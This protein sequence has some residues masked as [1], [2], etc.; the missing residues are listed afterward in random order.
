MAKR[1]L[2]LETLEKM[3]QHSKTKNDVLWVG[4]HDGKYCITWD[5]FSLLS[6]KEYDRDSPRQ[7]VA[8]DLVIA[9]NGWWLERKE[10]Q[11]TEWWVFLELPQKREGK[12]FQKIFC[13]E[14]KSKG[15]MSLEEI[16][17]AF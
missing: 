4:S 12:T 6:D 3:E 7:I 5:E 8:K 15:W 17:T 9:G 14:Q 1:N 2:L 13:D 10:Y 11:G 16:Q